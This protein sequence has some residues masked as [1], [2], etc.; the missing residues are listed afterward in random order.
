MSAVPKMGPGL[1]GNC[2]SRCKKQTETSYDLT[3]EPRYL[4]TA[5]VIIKGRRSVH[6]YALRWR[7]SCFRQTRLGMKGKVINDAEL[8]RDR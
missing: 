7:E 1:D 3:D 4:I 2:P 8:W 6:G 5:I